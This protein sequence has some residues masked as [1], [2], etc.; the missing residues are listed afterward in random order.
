MQAV[1]AIAL[2]GM[3]AALA[4]MAVAA[5]NVANL[6]TAGFHRQRASPVS[7]A[8]GGVVTTVARAAR[9]GSELASD[10]VAQ[11]SARN[12]FLVNLAVFRTADSMAARML[13][14]RA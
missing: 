13:N 2:S 5:H 14:V 1:N 3:N 6:G 10:V 9:P 12:A 11:L 7:V 8:G 4:G